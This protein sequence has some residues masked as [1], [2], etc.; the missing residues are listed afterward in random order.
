M[1]AAAGR[2]TRRSSATGPSGRAANHGQAASRAND[3]VATTVCAADE[4]VREGSGR[5][6]TAR[7]ATPPARE[8]HPAGAPG[9][10]QRPRGDEVGEPGDHQ[11]GRS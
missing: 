2:A 10:H 6:A 1:T 3:A 4:S 11:G 8:Q 9:G 7:V 5:A